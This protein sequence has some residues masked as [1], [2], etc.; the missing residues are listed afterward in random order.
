MIK[1]CIVEDNHDIREGLEEII[2]ESPDLTCTAT[3]SNAEAI[4]EQAAHLDA[5][6][7]VMDIHLPGMTGNECVKRLKQKV[8]HLQFLMFTIDDEDQQVFEAL[9][10][11]ATGYLLKTTPP[12]K[13]LEAIAEVYYGGSPMNARIARKL[14]SIFQDK[15][16]AHQEL[17]V[18]ENEVLQLIAKGLLYKE[19]AEKLFI[20]IGTVKQHLHRIYEKLHVQ[21]KTEAINKVFRT[22][23]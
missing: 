21:N 14:V 4:L 13:I 23:L 9:K 12:D 19:I 15:Q 8:P 1:V 16:P 10:A 20:S 3:F 5:E 2:N 22:N 11:G 18:R 17:S 6:V 7:V